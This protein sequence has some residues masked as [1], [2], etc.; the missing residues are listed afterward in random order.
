M[1]VSSMRID[2]SSRGNARSRPYDPGRLFSPVFFLS[3]LVNLGG[4]L[5]TTTLAQVTSGSLTGIV[6]DPSGAVV[7][8]ARVVLTDTNKGYEHPATTDAVGR[9][10]IA[11]LLP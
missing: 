6:S 1:E 2:S 10:V 8:E 11:N 5:A 3:L 9:Y 4:L 7:P